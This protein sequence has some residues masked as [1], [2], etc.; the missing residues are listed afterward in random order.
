MDDSFYEAKRNILRDAQ[1][2]NFYAVLAGLGISMVAAAFFGMTAWFIS[3]ATAGTMFAV[4]EV[5]IYLRLTAVA[6]ESTAA[7]ASRPAE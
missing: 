2:W 4:S 7:G 5:L 6:R 1:Q 3:L